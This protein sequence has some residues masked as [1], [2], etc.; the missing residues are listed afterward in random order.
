M[1]IGKVIDPSDTSFKNGDRVV[2][3]GI[4]AEI[5]RVP[6]NL[7][8]HVPDKVDDDTA[9]FTVIGAIALQGIRLMSN[10]GENVVVVGLGLIGLMAV[11]ILRANG[12]NVLL[13]I[14]TH[15]NVS[16]PE[17]FEWK[18]L[19]CLKQDPISIS[20]SFKGK[21]AD[22]VLITASSKSND[23]MHQLQPCHVRE[24]R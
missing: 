20:N 4:H 5:V 1:Y 19:I 12:C 3:N 16:L 15:Q 22:A 21:G 11:Q 18:Q 7:V 24:E 2:S 17:N 6:N 23:V 14:L 13:L 8:V 9:S 10:V